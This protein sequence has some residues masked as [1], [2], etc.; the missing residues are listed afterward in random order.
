[1]WSVQ[2]THLPRHKQNRD[3]RYKSAKT[4]GALAWRRQSL[5]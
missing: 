3:T 2:G 5:R 4:A 1:M